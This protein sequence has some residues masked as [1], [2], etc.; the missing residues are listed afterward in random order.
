MLAGF[1]RLDGPEGVQ[2]VGQRV[3]DGIHVGIGEQGVVGVEDRGDAVLGREGTRPLRVARRDRDHLDLVV[4]PRRLDQ[5]G[6]RD[7]R[8]AQAADADAVHRR[9]QVRA[10]TRRPGR[11]PVDSPCSNVTSPATRVAT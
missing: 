3:V 5:G 9:A 1:E 8:R 7:A 6:R 4:R 2:A 11:A 10:R